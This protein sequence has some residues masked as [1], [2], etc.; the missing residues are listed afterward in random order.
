MPRMFRSLFFALV[1]TIAGFAVAPSG[2]VGVP[3]AAQQPS[4]SAPTD[5]APSAQAPDVRAAV[6]DQAAALEADIRPL[7]EKIGKKVEALEQLLHRLADEARAR[8]VT[9]ALWA[10]AGL[11]VLMFVSSLL[12]GA[13]A[14]LLLRR[15]R[16]T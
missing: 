7:L 10:A 12:G 14:V 13:V 16:A 11:F 8:A 5:Q 9:Y 2:I 6:R 1:F 15:S 4:P 3:A